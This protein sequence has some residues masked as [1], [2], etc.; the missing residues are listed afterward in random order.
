[1][2]WA[3]FVAGCPTQVL[4]QWSVDDAA[5]ALLM[6]RFYQELKAGQ[7]KGTALRTAERELRRNAKYAHP[8]YWA[9]FQLVGQ[10]R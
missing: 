10:W 9:P 8:Y 4:S 5:T 2:T 7:P 1:M 3:L 6:T